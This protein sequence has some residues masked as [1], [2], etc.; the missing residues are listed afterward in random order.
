M[1]ADW[2]TTRL[3]AGAWSCPVHGIITP[4][5]GLVPH[6]DAV[7]DDGRTCMRMALVAVPKRGQPGMLEHAE[8]RPRQ[9]P[10]GHQLGPGRMLLGHRG[11][12]C[13]PAGGHRTWQ[14]GTCGDV[15]QWPPCG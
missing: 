12:Q 3:E 6:C 7:C 8:P 13:T 2:S 1:R 11:C 9:C 4:A 5:D 10:T 14:C 15:Q